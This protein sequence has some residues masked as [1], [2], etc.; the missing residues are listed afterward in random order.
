MVRKSLDMDGVGCVGCV[1]AGIFGRGK[2]K[3]FCCLE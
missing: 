1:G 2:R 3:D